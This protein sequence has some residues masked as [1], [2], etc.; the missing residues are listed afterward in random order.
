MKMILL[1]MVLTL[2]GCQWFKQNLPGN[3]EVTVTK[4]RDFPEWATRQYQKPM[5]ADGT[6]GARVISHD[7]RGQLID[8]LLCDR[9]LL[10]L[11]EKG[12]KVSHDQCTKKTSVA[13][14]H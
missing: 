4:Y 13:L 1:V 3:T 9:W 11:I 6:V 8:L 12:E 5:P 2:T 7:E 10:T 14:P